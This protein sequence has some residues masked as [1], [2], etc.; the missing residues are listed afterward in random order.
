MR[1]ALDIPMAKSA[2]LGGKSIKR[3]R[4]SIVWVVP[5]IA[6]VIAGYLVFE[7][8]KNAGPEISIAFANGDGLQV[9]QTI[10]RYRGVK[11]GIV[12]S[13][14]LSNDGQRVEVGVALDR[15]AERLAREGSLSWIVRPEVNA[16][17]LHGLE[18]IVSGAYIQ[19]EPG[20]GKEQKQ[21]TGRDETPILSPPAGSLDIVLRTP[22][23][24]TLNVAAPVYYRGLEVGTVQS[25]LLS[26]TANDV[27]IR[28]QI[29]PRYSSLVRENSEFWN[30]GGLDVSL[31]LFGIN[32]SAESMRSLIV[33]GI[34]FATP[35]P[36]GPAASPMSVFVLHEKPEEKWLKWAPSMPD[37]AGTNGPPTNMASPSAFPSLGALTNEGS[38]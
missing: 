18:T 7:R 21:F 9:N 17:G 1:G 30:A 32:V 3:A 4:V 11:V 20:R 16:G 6:A 27:N 36:P 19:V 23:V 37:W 31:K 38:H 33:G 34:A 10:L 2:A 24:G 35:S 13:V 25:L 26:E 12:H 5:I 8:V 22:Q 28:V 29:Q 15:S 14:K